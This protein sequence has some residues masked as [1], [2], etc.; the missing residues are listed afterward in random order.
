MKSHESMISL[1]RKILGLSPDTGIDLTPLTERGSDR[2][3]YRLQWDRSRSAILMHYSPERREN[4]LFAEIAA[5]LC[6]IGV[7]AARILGTEPGACAVIMEDL[8][9]VD[10]WSLRTESWENR[11]VLYRK[12]LAA[13]E[14]LHS[15]PVERFPLDRIPLAEAFGPSLYRWERDYFLENF[16][17]RLCRVR[18]ESGFRIG[19]EAELDRL[20]ERLSALPGCLVH[21]DLQSQNIMIRKGEPVWIDFQGMRLGTLFYDLGSLVYDP[22]A[23]LTEAEREELLFYYYQLSESRMKPDDFRRTFLEASVQ[24]LMQALGA[25][26]FLG[27]VKGLRSYLAHVRPGLGNLQLVLRNAGTLPCLE[28]LVSRCARIQAEAGHEAG[29]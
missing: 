7:P 5:F 4:V 29:V 28:E 18:L 21:R 26:G 13:V 27:T 17:G 22:Y 1:A 23:G 8:G 12:T 3:Y 25:Y 10:L 14:R 16:V 15:Y 24:R 9:D 20:A 6:G 2:S 19:L 11:S